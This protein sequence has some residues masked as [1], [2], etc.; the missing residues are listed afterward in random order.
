[1]S[2][3]VA[4]TIAGSDSSGGA[5]IQ[6]DLKTFQAF[7]VFGTSAITAITAQNTQGVTA[8]HAISA[9][10][11]RAQVHAVAVDFE[12]RAC[13]SGML[14]TRELVELVASLIAEEK[15]INYVLDPVMVA[16]SGDRLLDRD[17]EAAIVEKLLPLC[18]VVTP[19]LDEA[20]ILAGFS[21]T[22]QRSMRA[23]A[24][25]L[26]QKGARSALIKGGHL[27]ADEIVDVFFDGA[28]FS[29][30]RKPKL[31]TSSTHGTGCTLSAGIAAGLA[32][33]WDL[34]MAVTRG[35]G[36][37]QRA[38]ANAPGLGHGHGPL[39]HMVPASDR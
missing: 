23:A 33:G 16:T 14:A 5:G 21:V 10:M 22:D 2:I 38:L 25:K 27:Q 17:A 15:L 34:P 37:V 29:E 24:E 30:F 28:Q 6:A 35:L 1:M 3:P 13:K 11:V 7:G 39:N 8:V 31:A 26:V 20:G 19:N 4:L 32:H 12:I 18:T 9:D 36:F